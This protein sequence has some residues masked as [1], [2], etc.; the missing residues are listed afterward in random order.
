[1]IV[2]ADTLAVRPIADDL[3]RRAGGNEE[4]DVRSGGT[5]WSNEVPLHV[6][7][8]KTAGPSDTLG[9]LGAVFQ[10]QVGRVNGLLSTENARLLPTGMHPWMDP[11]TEFRIWPHA[12][13]PVYRTF[14]RIFDCRGHGWANLQSTHLN[15][16]FGDD[17]EFGRLHAAVRLVL[18]LLPG[19]AASSPF[20][21]GARSDHLDSRLEVYRKNARRVPSVSG[22][23]IPE[24]VFTRRDYE[25]RVLRVLYND[26]APL[27]PEGVIQHEWA[28][29]RGSIPRFGRMTVEIRV[30]DVQECPAADL[31]VAGATS[32]V[33]RAMVEEAWCDTKAQRKW[34]ERE[35]AEI[36]LDAVR[37]ADEAVTDNRR[38]L[39][40]FGFQ[41]R[42]RARI[43]DVWQHL[44]ESVVRDEP[45]YL[46][47]EA[48]LALIRQEGC[49]ARRIVRA[50]GDEV[51]RE[52]LHRAY[53]RLAECLSGGTLFRADA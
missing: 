53:G 35:L 25:E 24:P 2:D 42:G 26:L 51:S 33:V 5:I 50:V 28:N 17:A 37:D 32:A 47:W 44:V 31:A 40:A 12:N 46:E 3:L 34:D 30:L 18:P 16:P 36:F 20:F 6:L 7:E 8:L 13:S 19:L 45:G 14:D 4:L 10:E 15:L 38:F 39:D 11:A 29:A 49:L 27:D 48:P 21:D 9:G 22:H 23:V 1:M 43:G 52:S 41:E